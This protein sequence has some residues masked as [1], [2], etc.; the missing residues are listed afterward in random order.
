[1]RERGAVRL[2]PRHPVPVEIMTVGVAA[3][4]GLL[5][6]ISENGA[7]VWTETAFDE[8]EAL[9]LRLNFRGE[10]PP[11]QMA[12][13]VVWSDRTGHSANRGRCGVRWAFAEGPRHERLKALIRGC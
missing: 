2:I 10:S 11:F 7:C 8:G 13:Q 3:A 12:G 4:R 5:A 6:N 1:M 9:V